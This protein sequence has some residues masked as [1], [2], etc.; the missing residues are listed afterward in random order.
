MTIHDVWKDGTIRIWAGVGGDAGKLLLEIE[1]KEVLRRCLPPAVG[2]P[3]NP[4]NKIVQCDSCDAPIQW[5]VTDNGKRCPFSL[6]LLVKAKDGRYMIGS[7][8]LDCPDARKHSRKSAQMEF[9][10]DELP[11]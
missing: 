1:P 5:G 8:F 6:Q 9:G 7:H 4:D 10:D 2:I 3:F 11:S